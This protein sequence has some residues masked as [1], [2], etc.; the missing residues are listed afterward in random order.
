MRKTLFTKKFI[1]V[2]N[3]LYDDLT[4]SVRGDNNL[5]VKINLAD[6]ECCMDMDEFI[7]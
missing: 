1:V 5:G 6:F 4:L 7:E 2:K 3:Q